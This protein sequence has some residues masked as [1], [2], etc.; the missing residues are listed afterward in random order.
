VL[1]LGVFRGS[2]MAKRNAEGFN[3]GDAEIGAQR[4]QR[5]STAGGA[6]S[7]LDRAELDGWLSSSWSWAA[8]CGLEVARNN[9]DWCAR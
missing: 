1:A 7:S 4:S 8:S 5:I 6:N 9:P 2:E 3:A